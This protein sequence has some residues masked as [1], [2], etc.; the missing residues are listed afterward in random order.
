M[1]LEKFYSL[2]LV[3][4]FMLV[5]WN[6]YAFVFRLPSTMAFQLQVM[7]LIKTFE[8]NFVPQSIVSKAWI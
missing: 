2:F 5:R 7:R 1:K 6:F 3:R 4:C 8:C